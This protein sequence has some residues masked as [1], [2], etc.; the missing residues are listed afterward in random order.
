MQLKPPARRRS[1]RELDPDA[2]GCV[3]QPK[4]ASREGLQRV[5]SETDARGLDLL[6]RARASFARNP[7]IPILSNGLSMTREKTIKLTCEQSIERLKWIAA[8]GDCDNER[9][10]AEADQVLL[11]MLRTAGFEDV[12]AA[13]L[14]AK[15]EVGFWYC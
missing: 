14:K 6:L 12:A 7:P 8:N 5:P 13:W 10:H 1:Q 3:I 4:A 15:E 2:R 11:N 9:A